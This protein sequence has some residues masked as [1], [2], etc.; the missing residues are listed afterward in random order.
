MVILLKAVSNVNLS[1]GDSPIG[2]PTRLL[3][4]VND[5]KLSFDDSCTHNNLLERRH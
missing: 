1:Y 5:I 2:I 4:I 3:T